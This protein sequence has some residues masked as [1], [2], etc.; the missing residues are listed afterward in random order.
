ME[1]NEKNQNEQDVQIYGAR[2]PVKARR[3]VS[4]QVS[5]GKTRTDIPSFADETIVAAAKKAKRDLEK[6]ETAVNEV[7]DRDE[8]V[9]V[10]KTAIDN[11]IENFCK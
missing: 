10:I 1:N 5:D 3:E 2:R 9:K 7:Q 4:E 11:Y 6:K 8:A